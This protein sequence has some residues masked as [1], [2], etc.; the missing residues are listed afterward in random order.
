LIIRACVA[1]CPEQA[2]IINDMSGI[3]DG[4]LQ[5]EKTNEDGLR[6]K[7]GVLYF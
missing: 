1:A 4:K 5:M 6:Q 3:W 2:L 7:R